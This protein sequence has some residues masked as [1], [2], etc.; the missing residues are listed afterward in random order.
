[1][2]FYT[3]LD[4]VITPLYFLLILGVGYFI[5]L[6]HRDNP[7]YKFFMPGLVVKLLGA[8]AV[9]FVYSH[10]YGY[11]GDTISY[12]DTGRA[13]GNLFYKDFL[14]FLQVWLGEPTSEKLSLFDAETGYPAFWHDSS[15]LNVGKII[16]PFEIITVGGFPGTALLCGAL[17]YTGLWKLFLLFS[18]LYPSLYRKFAFSI[19][20]IP[21]VIFWGSGI[22]KDTLTMTGVCWYCFSFHNII[23]Q[24]KITAY[25]VGAIILSVLVMVLVKPYA[26]V[27]LFPGS[28]LW[29]VSGTIKKIKNVLLKF[30]IGPLIIFV[31]ILTGVSVWTVISPNMGRYSS[32]DSMIEKAYEAQLDLK[33]EY[34]RGNSF[35]IGEFEKTPMGVLSKFPEATIAGLFRPYIFE[36]TNVQMVISGL[37]N[38]FILGFTLFF[39]LRVPLSFFKQIIENP[40]VMFCIVFSVIFAFAVGLST[41]NFGA[42]VR[43]KIPIWPF[44][45]S[46]LFIIN[47]HR[48]KYNIT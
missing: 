44:Y 19:F 9:C 47:H 38:V 46:A 26:F 17:A 18:Q 28:I 33:S 8:L 23:I 24:R 45:L 27:A 37:E 12:H 32:V 1:M 16:V 43:F 15:A 7:L 48:I 13:I 3:E 42:L 30:I 40:M 14:G 4:F 36:A 29:G 6:K 20:F 35:D 5:R 10:Y 25:L 34:Y 31:G 2:Q 41:S 21:S 11:G 22:L 39:L